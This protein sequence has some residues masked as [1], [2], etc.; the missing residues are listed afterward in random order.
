MLLEVDADLAGRAFVE[1]GPRED[2]VDRVPELRR[3]GGGQRAH[4]RPSFPI[5]STSPA[6][7]RWCCFS[8]LRPA[9]VTA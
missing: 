2:G 7:S 3:E 5:A 1:V 6:N 8:H 9:A 4:V